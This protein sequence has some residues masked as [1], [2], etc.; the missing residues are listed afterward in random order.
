MYHHGEWNANHSSI[1]AWRIPWTENPT[2]FQSKGSQRVGHDWATKHMYRLSIQFHRV[3]I[4]I[5]PCGIQ[6]NDLTCVYYE[7]IALSDIS[8]SSVVYA[9]SQKPQHVFTSSDPD[10]TLGKTFLGWFSS[11]PG[12]RS[13]TRPQGTTK[14]LWSLIF[15]P[16][17][18]SVHTGVLMVLCSWVWVF[19]EELIW[20]STQM[21]NGPF[22]VC[23]CGVIASVSFGGKKRWELRLGVRGQL[24][25]TMNRTEFR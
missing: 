24:W 21:L 11:K 9:P 16:F 25:R 3:R 14:A 13:H 10:I 20:E 18:S 2:R 6:G 12:E 23:V 4:D 19:S 22:S 17:S 7:M 8:H 1:L 15:I 5:Q